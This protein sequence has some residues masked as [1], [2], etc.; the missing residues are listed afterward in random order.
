MEG[1]EASPTSTLNEESI[2]ESVGPNPQLF[3]NEVLNSV[4]DTVE[5]AFDFFLQQ[6]STLIGGDA[7][8]ARNDQLRQGVS[9][10]RHTI[11]HVLDNRLAIWEKYCLQHCFAVPKGFSFPRTQD[12]LVNDFSLHDGLDDAELDT[13][14][15]ALREK[16]SAVAKESKEL[17]KEV[18]ALE[19]Q[20]MV[21]VN[22]EKSIAEAIRQLEESTNVIPEGLKRAATELRQKMK[23]LDD[24]NREL[25]N[26]VRYYTPNESHFHICNGGLKAKLD[27]FPDFVNNLKGS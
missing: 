14:L 20:A 25:L 10:L 13:E 9:S 18:H 2:F 27:T 21:T 5:G 19:K 22:F 24:D 23:K 3:I 12:P 4:D 11:Q 1:E 17:H 6:A 16:L 26:N 7:N 15:E 8:T